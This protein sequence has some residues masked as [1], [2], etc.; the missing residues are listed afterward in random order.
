MWRN[1][2]VCLVG[3]ALALLGSG[4]VAYEHDHYPSGGSGGYHSPPPPVV[5]SDGARLAFEWDLSYVDGKPAD[6]ESA[7]TPTVT[8]HLDPA[9]NG[10]P[11]DVNFPCDAGAGLATGIEP[12]NY[13][14]TLDLVD[15]HG[16]VVASLT[17]PPVGLF[18]GTTTQL[19]DPAVLPVQ[20]W[21]LAWTI[22]QRGGR[23]LSCDDV[24][25][26]SVQFT[27]QLGGEPPQSYL[28]PCHDYQAVTTAIPA[29]DYNVRMLLLDHA[30]RAIGDT[31]PGLVRVTMDAVATLDADF[32]L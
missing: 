24:N 28:L 14:V 25:G 5:V 10:T 4:C 17:H 27:A 3:S 32:N 23:P 30:G 7:D 26:A 13:E 8:L 12:G 21:D 11:V 1:S 15:V 31:G 20:T 22:G 6:C 18:V 19:G 9:P 2:T 29:G 16:R